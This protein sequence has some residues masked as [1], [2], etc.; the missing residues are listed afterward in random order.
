MKIR[1]PLSLC[2]LAAA[3][4]AAHAQTYPAKPVRVISAVAGGGE[5]FARL[6]GAKMAEG[7]GQP[8]L[9]E[10]NP[11]ASGAIA[12]ST[13]A[14]SPPDGYTLL[15][16]ATNSQIYRQVLTKNTPYDSVKDFSPIGVASEA[17]LVVAASLQSGITNMK[18]L[19]EQ[20]RK[21]PGKI[22]YGT[23][24]AGTT[25]HLSAELLQTVTG[26]KLTHVPYKDPTQVATELVAGRLPVGL[27]I[28]GL[29]YPQHA[30]GKLRVIALNNTK[31]YAK[32]PDIPTVGEQ[33][34]GYV[35]PPGW[36]GYFG[37]AG[38][39]RQVVQRLNTELNK[40]LTAPELKDKFDALGFIPAP[41]T[42]EELGEMVKRDL[43]R[44]AK[45]VKA[46][47]IEPE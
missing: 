14:K 46:A 24:G 18:D 5:T 16:A 21:D 1:V 26:V 17:L 20:A 19:V 8:M 44:S 22:F 29:M 27:G 3:F 32:S 9:V 12:A 34:P 6:V 33:I 45:L 35:P 25:H 4:G 2:A 13:V 36:N 11:A 41:G 38:M 7:L 30:A 39:Q 47:G 15:Y 31:R 28:Y 40:A 42:P 23:S 43:E 37:P 10:I